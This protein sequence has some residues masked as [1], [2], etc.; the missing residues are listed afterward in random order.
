MTDIEVWV[1]TQNG[2]V[3]ESF[4]GQSFDLVK[5]KWDDLAR[6]RK[7]IIQLG[8][9]MADTSRVIDHEIARRLDTL[10]DRSILV[11]DVELKVNA[12]LAPEWDVEKLA[13]TLVDLVN[14]GRLGA[15][16]PRRCLKRQLPKPVARELAK[17][18]QHDDPRVRELVG[19]C[20][21]MVPVARRVAVK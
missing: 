11:G 13:H 21:T 6:A 12:P 18:L 9:L 7:G 14:E 20:R 16:V 3:V 17:L 4:T 19:E 5:A 10:N 2:R 8:H 1:P 15:G